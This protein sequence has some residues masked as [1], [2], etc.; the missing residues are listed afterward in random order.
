MTI[1][2]IVKGL[3]DLAPLY[4]QEAYDNSGLQIGDSGDEATGALITLDVTGEVIDEA[5]SRGCN[6]IV[7][8]HPLIFRPLKHLRGDSLVERCVI[9]AIRHRIALMVMHTNLDNATGG[10]NSRLAGLLGVATPKILQPGSGKLVKIVVY[11][12]SDS[13]V[14][15]KQAMFE[16]GAGAIGNYDNCS[17]MSEGTGSFRALEGATPFLGVPGTVHFEKEVRIE[18]IVQAA[19][20]GRVLKAMLEAHPYEEVA[21]DVI[22]LENTDPHS[23]AGAFGELTSGLQPAEFLERVKTVLGVNHVRHTRLPNQLIKRIGVCGG[24]GAFLIERAISMGIDALVTADVKYHQF[25]DAQDRILL[26]DAGHYET[27]IVMTGLIYDE[28]RKKFPT[29]ACY[30]SKQNTNPV[31]YS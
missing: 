27:E 15:V 10:L 24:S 7:A 5:I 26:I 30:I 19:E 3:T 9:R 13:A 8:H 12:P 1:A 29:F 22:A 18:M 11:C 2:E 17:F 4:L 25:F 23:G 28:M 20:S 6:L 14:V 31:K 21:H 16:A